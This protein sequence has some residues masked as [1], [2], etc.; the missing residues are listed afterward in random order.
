MPQPR[1]GLAYQVV[2]LTFIAR[3]AA[4]LPLHAE[5]TRWHSGRLR[6]F[7]Y[8]NQYSPGWHW[9][10]IH[11][12]RATKALA[13]RELCEQLSV[14]LTNLTVFGDERNDIPCSRSP[15]EPWPWLTLTRSSSRSRTS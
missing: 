2:C 6:L 9:L 3:E 8:E 12:H 15:A 7:C 13:V 4:L 5:L 11:D 14:P 1:R 10:S